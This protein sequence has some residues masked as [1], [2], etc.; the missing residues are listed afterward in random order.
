MKEYNK[1]ETVFNRDENGSKKL[2]DNSFRSE[3]VEYLKDNQWIFT[4]KIDGTNI[5]VY[6][7]GHKVQ[8][9]GRTDNSQIPSK[10]LNKLLELFGGDINEELFEQKFGN[11][12]VML[13]G[14]G[15][16]GNIQGN[17]GYKDDF[18]FILFDI[19]INNVVLD[20][21][22]CVDIAKYFNTSYVPIVFEGTIKEA[23]D[24]IKTSPKSTIGNANMEGLVGKP[25]IELF[26]KKGD[27]VIVKIKVKDFI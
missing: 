25:K 7:D 1:I 26:N 3:V 23:V 20:K 10:L 18:D 15:F 12:E 4:E 17:L 9:S 6:W 27:R 24:Y 5:R 22:S 16:G 8:F 2:I 21:D 19:L 14:E 11:S 13:C